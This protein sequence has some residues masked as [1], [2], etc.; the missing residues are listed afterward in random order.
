[1]NFYLSYPTI[2]A[3]LKQRSFKSPAVFLKP[4]EIMKRSEYI[5]SQ[6]IEFMS[7]ESQNSRWVEGQRR[8]IKIKFKQ[9]SRLNRVLDIACGDG[10]G[11]LTL[12][13]MGFQNVFGVDSNVEKI[14]EAVKHAEAF[15][16]DMHDLSFIETNSVNIILSSH[17]LEHVFDP[18][19]VLNEFNRILTRDGILLLVLP[20]PDFKPV[21]DRAHLAKYILGLHKFDHGRSL[22][23]F[24]SLS[25][26]RV[27]KVQFDSFREDEI[28]V[29]AIPNRV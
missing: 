28:W 24:I 16:A 29:T 19:Q 6:N 14:S 27:M 11:L 18:S 15:V 13:E 5:D 4:E 22:R 9:Y 8:F 2:K 26:F 3:Q 12:K 23:K 21:N 17:S 10:I 20:Y 7:H 1:M 25:G